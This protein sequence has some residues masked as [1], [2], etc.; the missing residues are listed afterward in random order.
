MSQAEG[1]YPGTCVQIG[2]KTEDNLFRVDSR[3]PS[4]KLRLLLFFDGILETHDKLGSLNF[5]QKETVGIVAENQTVKREHSRTRGTT[6]AQC[7]TV[8][9]IDVL[10]R[11]TACC[12]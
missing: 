2:P 8:Q 12:S 11:Q 6:C 4:C 10:A 3:L 9:S 1:Q 7:E 5:D